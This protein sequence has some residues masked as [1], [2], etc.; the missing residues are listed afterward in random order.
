MVK[1]KNIYFPGSGKKMLQ[2]GVENG[3]GP[4]QKKP[5]RRKEPF[6]G[7]FMDPTQTESEP[8][9]NNEEAAPGETQSGKADPMNHQ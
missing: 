1:K 9:P 3:L 7:V 5:K 2:F 8:R 6:T 4:F